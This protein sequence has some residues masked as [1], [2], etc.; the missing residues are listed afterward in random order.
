MHI[1]LVAQY[2]AHL[3]PFFQSPP[4]PSG[5]TTLGFRPIHA[6]AQS[7]T[8]S[9]KSTPQ[10]LLHDASQSPSEY[11][12]SASGD[13]SDLHIRTRPI[14]IRRPRSRPPHMTSWAQSY[15]ATQPGIVL[16]YS[17]SPHHTQAWVAPDYADIDGEWDDVEIPGP[18]VT[19]RQTLIALA[20]MASDAYIL[21]GTDEWWPVNGWNDTVPFGWEADADG[22]RGHIFADPKN[23]TVIIAIKGTSAGVLGSGGPTAKNDKYNVSSGCTL[24]VYQSLPFRTTCSSRAAARGLTSPGVPSATAML[25][26]TTAS[27]PVW[28]R[29]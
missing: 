1:P 27:R 15:F 14:T 18:D 23:E 11:Q 24:G 28:R 22:L 26:A 12:A 20:K 17:S 25:A 13:G 5:P 8:S 7:K 6:H 10:L 2:A 16:P 3:L 9:G 29:L 19:D 21:P 4:P